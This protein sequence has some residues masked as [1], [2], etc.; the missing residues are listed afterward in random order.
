VL[1]NARESKAVL[2]EDG[3]AQRTAA[4]LRQLAARVGLLWVRCP[5][6]RCDQG[7]YQDGCPCVT[8]GGSGVV[9][10]EVFGG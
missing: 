5:E 3:T 2:E 6:G 7:Y 4:M 1:S 10:M 9:L 8:C